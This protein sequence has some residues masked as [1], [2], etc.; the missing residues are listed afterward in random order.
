MRY[1]AGVAL[2]STNHDLAIQDETDRV[3]ALVQQRSALIHTLPGVVQRNGGRRLS[4]AD[5]KAVCA[6]RVRLFLPEG[7]E[8][9]RCNG[10][11]LKACIDFFSAQIR[12]LPP[13]AVPVEHPR[14][15]Q[16]PGQPQERQRLTGLGRRRGGDAAAARL[17]R[18]PALL[19][20]EGRPW[21][22]LRRPRRPGGADRPPMA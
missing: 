2:H 21:P 7:A 16:G 5:I 8:D 22:A 17:P 12:R 4:A 15:D 1:F 20:A 13:G 14:E 9:L 11:V 18:G 3:V 6:D 19:P 10:Q